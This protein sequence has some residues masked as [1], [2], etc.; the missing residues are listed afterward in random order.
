ME[1]SQS[2]NYISPARILTD[3]EKSVIWLRRHTQ[4]VVMKTTW[5]ADDYDNSIWKKSR[6]AHWDTEGD[7]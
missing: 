5:D 1:I 6:R 7:K 3:T 4:W 2:T